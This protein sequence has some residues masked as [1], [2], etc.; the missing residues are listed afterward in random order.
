METEFK[1]EKIKT[2]WFLVLM[3]WFAGIA[4][5]MQ[6]A[7]FSVAF[8][9]L[10]NQYNVTPFWIGLSLSI[11]GF[12]GLVFGVTISIYVSKIGQNKILLVSLLLGAIVSVVQALQP[13]FPILFLS[14]IVEGISHLG[15]A[16]TAPIIMIIISSEKHHSIVMGLWSTFFFFFFSVTAWIGKPILELYS[17]SVLF[18]IHAIF[19][20]IIL[21]ILFFPIRQINIPFNNNNKISF[22]DAHKKVYSNWR[23]FSPGIL[24]FFH[25]FMYIALFTFLPGLSGNEN[26]R[27]LLLVIL[28]LISIAGTM[29]AGIAS[30][31]FISPSKLSIFAYI[32]LLA[33]ILAVRLS[34][35]NNLLFV[36]ASMIL[37]LFSGIIQG[38]VFSL[39]P[40]ISLT[41]EDQTNA[42]GSVAQ[43]G[44]LGSTLGSPVFSYFL[45]YGRDSI[46]IIVMLLSLLGA[47]SGIYITKK[48]RRN[49]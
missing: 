20:T 25:T 7:K 26:T 15:I 34:F 4:A 38:S 31:Y 39:I 28:P 2:N 30:Q 17:S 48:I 12:I 14:R 3:L 24:F 41:T 23:T 37:I 45:V 16:V 18:L 1:M 5:A 19:M 21:I 49:K 27:S 44:N 33:L 29:I 46:I 13:V 40:K 32:S 8:D 22:I 47:I 11:V 35:D 43:L 10:G 36:I 6:F 9:F 42:N